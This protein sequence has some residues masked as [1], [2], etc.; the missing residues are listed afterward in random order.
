M[1]RGPLYVALV[2]WNQEAFRAVM[3]AAQPVLDG[4][5]IDD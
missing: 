3:K 1:S 4:L 2:G 5:K